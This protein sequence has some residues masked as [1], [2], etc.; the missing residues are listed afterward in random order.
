ML[1]QPPWLQPVLHSL[2]STAWGK[3]GLGLWARGGSHTLLP[4]GI[5]GAQGAYFCYS[6]IKTCTCV[7]DRAESKSSFV[8]GG[9]LS[10]IT[11]AFTGTPGAAPSAER[12]SQVHCDS[13]ILMGKNELVFYVLHCFSL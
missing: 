10:C 4:H 11:A 9:L 6:S 5:L 7:R 2:S 12:P 3:E 13:V 1:C 8:Q